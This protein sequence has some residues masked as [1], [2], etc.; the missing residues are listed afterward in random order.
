MTS[1]PSTTTQTK[2]T[3]TTKGPLE[4]EQPLFSDIWNRTQSVVNA[5]TPDKFVASPNQLSFDAYNSMAGLAP[6]LGS[7]AGSLRDIAGKVANGYFLDPTNDP[8][9]AGAANAAIRPI[10]QQL[11]EKVLPQITDASIRNGGVGG[12]PAAYGGSRQDIQE[13]QAVRDWTQTAGDITA[14]LASASR[15]QGMALIPQAGAIDSAATASA[16]MPSTVTQAAGAGLTGLDQTG[17]NDT[18]AKWLAPLQALT[19]AAGIASAGGFNSGTENSVGTTTTPPPSIATQWLQGLTGAAGIASS[20]FGLPGMGAI[21][22]A[23]GLGGNGMGSIF[24]LLKL[25]S[26]AN[27]GA[28]ISSPF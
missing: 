3:K 24:D 21:T 13:N 12:G 14:K 25:G 17:L 20:I 16:L 4:A 8:T 1:S 23:M 11:T 9:F 10:T 19:P 27:T 22:G 6:S 2:N 15:G 5:P 18:I 26:G 7:N 28:P